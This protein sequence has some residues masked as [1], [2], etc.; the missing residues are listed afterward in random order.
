MGQSSW[1][2]T[3]IRVV[4]RRERG[5]VADLRGPQ[6]G[7]VGGGVLS[8]VEDHGYRPRHRRHGGVCRVA[9][10]QFSEHR[11]EL[12]HVGFVA[13]IGVRQQRDPAVAGDDQ[14]QTD[15]T[16]IGALLLGFA[17]LGQGCL[18]VARVD[19]GS[20][21]RHVQGHRRDVQAEGGDHLGD[22]SAF[23]LGQVLGG[24]GAGGIPEPAVVQHARVDTGE[25]VGRGGGPPV[26]QAAPRARVNE[27]V[28]RGQGQIRAHRR[29]RVGA[30]RAHH[31]V[32]NVD[33]P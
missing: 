18:G 25:P 9:G 10:T 28:Q 31:L 12:G 22:H 33:H 17:P 30:S 7:E 32:N 4:R 3:R 2:V 27:A 21:V 5:D 23:D 24:D 15:Q 13:G 11:G 8:G 16:Q 26:G 1:L 19:E 29:T 20:E 14:A 6:V